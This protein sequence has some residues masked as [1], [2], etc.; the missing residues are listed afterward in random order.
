MLL[1]K[2][3]KKHHR[4]K[5]GRINK[6]FSI[7]SLVTSYLFKISGV[8]IFIIGIFLALNSLD[9]TFNILEY[10]SRI[11]HA[12]DNQLVN[13]VNGEM[14]S[15]IIYLFLPG[16]LLLILSGILSK[17]FS[18]YMYLLTLFSVTYFFVVQCKIL[19][20][21]VYHGGEIYPNL[22]IAE[23]FLL[24]SI[25]GLFINSIIFK[26][27]LILVSTSIYFFLTTVLYITLYGLHLNYSIPFYIFFSLC[28]AWSANKINSPESNLINFILGIGFFGLFWI[29]KLAANSQPEYIIPFYI[30]GALIYMIFYGILFYAA[31]DKEKPMPKWMQMVMGFSNF[32]FYAGTTGF[33]IVKYYSFDYLWVFSLGLLLFNIL[34]LY[35]SV[36]YFPAVWKLPLHIITILLA[37][38]V[39]PMLLNQN[40][41][42]IFTAGLSLLLLL[43]SRYSKNQPFVIISMIA[44]GVMTLDFFF[45]WI[46]KYIPPLISGST[47]PSASLVWHGIISSI[48]VIATLI[49]NHLFLKNIEISL[50]KNIFNKTRYIRLIKGLLLFSVFLACGWIISNLLIILSK[51]NQLVAPGWFIIVLP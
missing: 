45:H 8:I 25:I 18:F 11:F 4:I 7:E 38:L 36:K 16:I 42:L 1:T 21:N 5:K 20:Y 35:L 28:I 33:V 34:G 47:L 14:D 46:F 44:M 43:Y 48:V 40:T 10:I 19:I 32:L 31:L 50:P 22:L 37:A 2:R 3:K 41:V 51:S 15:T 23:L 27:T 24:F 17:R 12:T 13:E 49:L 26:R 30:Y 39:L 29:R 9:A 6:K